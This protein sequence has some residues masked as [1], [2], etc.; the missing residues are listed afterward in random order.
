V[1]RETLV[2]TLELV[3]R[4]LGDAKMVQVFSNFCFKNRTVSAYNDEIGI[5]A[6]CEVLG[7]YGLHGKTLLDL[8]KVTKT[9]KVEF[10][11]VEEEVQIVSGKSKL[12][13][14]Y[15]REDAFLFKPVKEDLYTVSMDITIDLIDGL[16][17]SLVTSSR[18]QSMGA[19]MGVQLYDEGPT[20]ILFSCDSDA[21][22]KYTLNADPDAGRAM[23]PLRFM[24]SN[25]FCET[26]LK[27]IKESGSSE[28][29]ITFGDDW[30]VAYLNNGWRIYGRMKPLGTLDHQNMITDTIKETP[31]FVD[32]PE[33]L[34]EALARASV[35]AETEGAGTH[36][37]INQGKMSLVTQT[38][39]GEV[40]DTVTLRDHADVE[41]KVNPSLMLRSIESCGRFCVQ[42]NCTIF[43]DGDKP[44]LVLTANMGG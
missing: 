1:N 28:G 32:V 16:G 3:G 17:Y 30:V 42:E 2:Q 7:T 9:E 34:K 4:A 14:P 6:P 15:L 18:D 44:L 38:K 23:T 40:L 11:L 35:M 22:T 31:V 41:A 13:L 20:S 19:L 8:L 24:L 10:N 37:Q 36:I 33:A 25:A 12:K 26:L 5:V 39:M 21:I 43:E 27:V 29:R